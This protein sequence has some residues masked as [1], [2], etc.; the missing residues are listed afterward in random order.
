MRLNKKW[1]TAHLLNVALSSPKF[2]A[3]VNS[4]EDVIS[5]DVDKNTGFVTWWHNYVRVTE[6]DIANVLARWA[7]EGV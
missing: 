3:D 1:T 6:G 2:S 4:G 7:V 5:V